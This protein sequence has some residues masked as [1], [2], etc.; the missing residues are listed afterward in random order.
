M[1]VPHIER[2]IRGRTTHDKYVAR[3]VSRQRTILRLLAVSLVVG[4]VLASLDL[5]FG[6]LGWPGTDF[7]A[8][9]ARAAHGAMLAGE[10]LL[11]CLLGGAAIVVPAWLIH[12]F[13]LA[14]LAR[15]RSAR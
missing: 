7:E 13:R 2:K 3:P 8:L 6:D 1:N 12:R 14:R 5:T 15:R 4:L 9:A 10:I 11:K